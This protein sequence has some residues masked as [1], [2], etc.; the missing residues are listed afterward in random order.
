[1]TWGLGCSPSRRKEKG[2]SAWNGPKMLW[3]EKGV[4]SKSFSNMIGWAN[5]NTHFDQFSGTS[6]NKWERNKQKSA[7]I[8]PR[9]Y[10]CCHIFAR[11]GMKKGSYKKVAVIWL[12][13]LIKIH[14]LTNFQGLWLINERGTSKNVQKLTL[15][16]AFSAIYLLVSACKSGLIKKL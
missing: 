8:D 15:V 2:K 5:Q 3:H 16:A 6:V 13:K 4:L 7:K 14:I 1:M 11:F 10:L 12:V 9:H